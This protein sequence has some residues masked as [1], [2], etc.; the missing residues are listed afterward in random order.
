MNS[1]ILL[2]GYMGISIIGIASYF[3]GVFHHF[4]LISLLNQVSVSFSK[5]VFAQNKNSCSKDM[6][7]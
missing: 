4:G 6:F 3:L 1:V 5:L 7:V 2:L